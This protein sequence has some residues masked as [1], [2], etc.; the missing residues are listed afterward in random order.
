[1]LQDNK[2]IIKLDNLVRDLQKKLKEKSSNNKN[3]LLDRT[4]EKI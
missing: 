1:M 4:P 3:Q 2:Y